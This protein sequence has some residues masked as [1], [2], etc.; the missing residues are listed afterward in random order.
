[1]T[2]NESA[3]EADS[4]LRLYLLVQGLE[5]ERRRAAIHLH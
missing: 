1:V 3:V 2:L 4:V 5:P